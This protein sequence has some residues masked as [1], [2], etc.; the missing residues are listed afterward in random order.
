MMSK[1]ME[2][3]GLWSA[4]W[5][6]AAC[7]GVAL[8][9]DAKSAAPAPSDDA[10][11]PVTAITKPS[12]E[13]KLTFAAPG[14]VKDVFVNEG[15]H[16]KAGQVLAHQDDRQDQAELESASLEAKSQAKIDNY[17]TDEAVKKVQLDRK[18]K[19][20]A[21][22]HLASEEEVEEAKLDVTLAHTQVQLAD[23]EHAQKALDA[24]KLSVK[25]DQEQ[26]T[27]PLD[28]VVEKRNINPGEM[29]SADPAN[30]DGSIVVVQND[31]LWAEMHLPTAQALQ[32]HLGDSLQVR[33]PGANWDPKVTGKIIFFSPQADAASDTEL[34]RLEL[35]NPNSTPSGLQVQ[36]K[37]PEKVAAVAENQ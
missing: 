21:D 32:L 18:Q 23:L 34:V 3:G 26:I 22:G 15:D 35:P 8:A 12:L 29:A 5:V 6:I 33:T 14:L 16:V 19:L 7:C 30:R 13:V 27:S 10:D 17:R 25:V 20:L 4:G 31:P 9:Q 24:Q 1:Q 11:K 37:L 28:G 2:R 36:V